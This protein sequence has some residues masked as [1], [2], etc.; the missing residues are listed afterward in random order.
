M[1]TGPISTS[2]GV[3]LRIRKTSPMPQTPKVAISTANRIFTIQ[4]EALLRSAVSM[5]IFYRKRGRPVS[6]RE[7]AGI[8]GMRP[9]ASNSKAAGRKA[10]IQPAPRHASRRRP[11]RKAMPATP[12]ARPRP[13]VAGNWKMNGRRADGLALAGALVAQPAREPLRAEL[14]ICPPATLLC[15]VGA[16]LAGSP[17]GLGAQDCHPK[18]SGAHTGD[19]SAPML[20]DAGCRYVIVGHSERRAAY[21]ESDALVK[22]KASAALAAGL[23]PIVCLG[24]TETERD[25]GQ[26][27]AVVERQLAGS[28]PAVAP[29]AGLVVAYEPVWAIGSG[30]T[31]SA[32][33]IA[34]VHGHLRRCLAAHLA[35]PAQVRLLYGGSVKAAN[36]PE[37]LAIPEVDGA[38][39]GGASLKADEFWAIA[40]SCA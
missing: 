8:I 17:I 31:P 11:R 6:G 15:E 10:A 16:R 21:H 4:D 19:L 23:T 5:T 2:G 26:A 34:A 13:L 22:E 36:A 39:V 3:A 29:A 28:L 35:A 14:A 9:T 1:C 30:R 7:T 12:A 20:A 18:P 37:I 25:A 24:E 27:L 38:L 32:S 33:D 40:A